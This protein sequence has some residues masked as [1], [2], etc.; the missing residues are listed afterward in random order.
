[1]GNGSTRGALTITHEEDDVFGSLRR[2][3]QGEG[4][5]QPP[6]GPLIPVV[7]GLLGVWMCEQSWECAGPQSSL[8]AP[9]PPCP[10]LSS[11]LRSQW[12]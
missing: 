12:Q 7:W 1:M 11:H 4:C 10:S 6:P 9:T 3:L 5:F 2:W 8:R